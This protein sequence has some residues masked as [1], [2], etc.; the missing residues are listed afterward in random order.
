[1]V[2]LDPPNKRGLFDFVFSRFV[3]G[4]PVPT[5]DLR[6]RLSNVTNSYLLNCGDFFQL[7]GWEFRE[8]KYDSSH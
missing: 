2:Y 8:A 4:S 3:F 6:S 7:L 5:S 1:M